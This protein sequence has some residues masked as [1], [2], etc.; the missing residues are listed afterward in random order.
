MNLCIPADVDCECSANTWDIFYYIY[1][2]YKLEAISLKYA[3][4]V[5]D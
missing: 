4:F 5:S 1:S 2:P 3:Y